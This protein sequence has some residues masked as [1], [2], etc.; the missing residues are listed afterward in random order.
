MYRYLTIK[1][2]LS[3]KAFYQKMASCP[4]VLAD[5]LHLRFSRKKLSKKVIYNLC[6]GH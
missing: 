1:E 5:E 3:S 2:R 6:R 4:S